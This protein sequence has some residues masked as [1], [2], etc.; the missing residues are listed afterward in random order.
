MFRQIVEK[1]FPLR[2]APDIG[3]FMTIEADQ[4]RSD[5]IE[6]SQVG[7]RLERFNL[8]DHT[9]HAEQAGKVSKHGKLI[10]IEPEP[11]VAE[12]LSDVKEISCTAAKIENALRAD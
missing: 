9:T 11:F 1:K 10:Q 12:Q 2:H 5:E 8:P 4:E 6:F 3:L 7:Q